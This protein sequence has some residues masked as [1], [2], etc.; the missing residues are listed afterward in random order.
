MRISG[1]VRSTTLH[2][3]RLHK[4]HLSNFLN[5][6]RVALRWSGM[7]VSNLLRGTSNPS[8]DEVK[9]WEVLAPTR[10]TIN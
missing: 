1:C 7:H 2:T 4:S 6:L 3:L 10:P 5:G 8:Y 9:A